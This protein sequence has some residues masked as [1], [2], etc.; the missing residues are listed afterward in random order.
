MWVLHIKYTIGEPVTVIWYVIFI[1]DHGGTQKGLAADHLYWLWHFLI[2][3]IADICYL[4][5]IRVSYF[6]C[7]NILKF[8]SLWA[9]ILTHMIPRSLMFAVMSCFHYYLMQF[10]IYCGEAVCSL[11][12]LCSWVM[13]FVG[14]FTLPVGPLCLA[15]F[16]YLHIKYCDFAGI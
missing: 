12:Y 9:Q 6:F 15:D 2:W 10:A 14:H 3:F 16:C 5:H 8:P 4:C 11:I 7:H 13:C 1:S